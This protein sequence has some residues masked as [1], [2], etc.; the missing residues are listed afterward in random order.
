[1]CSA[2]RDAASPERPS[3]PA[4]VCDL[5]HLNPN[6]KF[7]GLNVFGLAFEE[8]GMAEVECQC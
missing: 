2:A 5:L 6:K 1:M 4:S 3:S 7:D 8:G